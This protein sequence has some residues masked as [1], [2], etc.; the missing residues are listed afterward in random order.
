MNYNTE[1]ESLCLWKCHPEKICLNCRHLFIYPENKD[2]YFFMQCEDDDAFW[3]YYV[4]ITESKAEFIEKLL[5]AR[6]CDSFEL[7][8]GIKNEI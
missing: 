4:S 7:K 5:T 6:T 3:G 8:V 2:H 1:D